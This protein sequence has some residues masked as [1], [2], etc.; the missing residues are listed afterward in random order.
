MWR[1]F[2]LASALSLSAGNSRA[3]LSMNVQTDDG[4]RLAYVNLWGKFVSGDDRPEEKRRANTP[5]QPLLEL[6]GH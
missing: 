5:R 2:F 6:E 3:A 4:E 1:K